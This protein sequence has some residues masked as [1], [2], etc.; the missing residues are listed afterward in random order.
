MISP[1][2]QARLSISPPRQVISRQLLTNYETAGSGGN[3]PGP[4]VV[5]W[6]RP[7]STGLGFL[8]EGLFKRLLDIQ[9]RPQIAVED[10]AVL[11]NQDHRRIVVRDDPILV[12]EPAFHTAR[13]EDGRPR[14]LGALNEVLPGLLLA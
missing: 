14:N 6:E 7:G 4:A 12:G 3:P 13:L 9:R 10:L 1:F 8:G 2:R 5:R 11:V